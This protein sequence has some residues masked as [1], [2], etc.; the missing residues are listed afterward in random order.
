[1]RYD[2]LGGAVLGAIATLACEAQPET[3]SATPMGYG[4]LRQLRV[5]TPTGV[6][7]IGQQAVVQVSPSL[8]DASREI[9]S[10]GV[11]A[12]VP[13]AAATEPPVHFWASLEVLANAMTANAIDV[14]IQWQPSSV[15]G[16]PL[17][18]IPTGTARVTNENG[19]VES[20]RV[21]LRLEP[22]RVTGRADT[23]A[24]A[25]QLSGK[26]S[27]ECM[28]TEVGADGVPV[29]LVLDQTFETPLCQRFASLRAP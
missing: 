10:F 11:Y 24:G 5:L 2:L 15:P 17:G 27:V 29:G 26:L 13:G 19:G 18:S 4:D 28:K 21:Y 6:E 16:A 20:G 22:G 23:P 1:M 25:Y 8:E 3:P 14:P 9:V 7:L 12:K